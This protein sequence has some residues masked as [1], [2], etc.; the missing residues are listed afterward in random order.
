MQKKKSK[1]TASN[2]SLIKEP[3][4]S[5]E[6]DVE[7]ELKG[8]TA[9][10]FEFG[11]KLDLKTLKTKVNVIAKSKVIGA[12]KDEKMITKLNNAQSKD[13]SFYANF[14]KGDGKN[15]K[16]LVCTS[17]PIFK[18]EKQD[19]KPYMKK[20]SIEEPELEIENFDE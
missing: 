11:D 20:G 15:I 2:N 9:S 3:G 1:H 16:I 5:K 8:I 6:I 17:A 10:S 4:T 12:I 13:I 18:G 7:I 19:I 14:L